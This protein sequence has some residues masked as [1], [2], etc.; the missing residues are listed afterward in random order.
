MSTALFSY[1]RQL[2]RE[3]RD[4]PWK[5][6]LS[7]MTIDAL[8]TNASLLS[9]FALWFLFYVVILR[10][11]DPQKLAE[12]FKGYVTQDWLF[13][14]FLA[15]LVFQLNGLY[16]RTRGT[17][18]VQKALV[19][20]R[21]VSLFIVLFVFADYFLFRGILVPRGVTLLGW[22]LMLLTVGGSRLA[23][24]RVLRLYNVE[25]KTDPAKAK[26]IL[27]LG[28]AGYLGSVLT[29]QLL[30]RGFA[31]RILD[32]FLFGE[33]SLEEVRTHPN[34]EVIRG[35]VR[36][37]GAVVQSMRGCDAVV[38]LAA[39]VGDSACEENKQLALE[40]N[41]AATRMLVDVARGYGVRRFIFASSCSVYGAS[42]ATLDESSPLNPLSLYA[43]TKVDSENIILGAKTQEFAPTVLR[44]ATLFGLS[45]RMRFDLVVNLFVARAISSGRIRVVN[46]EQWRPFLHVADAGRAVLA[47]I[48]GAPEAVSGEV[49]NAGAGHLNLR[50]H[51]VAS[52]IARVLPAVQ[53]EN[54]ESEDRRNYRVS[55]EK[56]ERML[57]FTA[58]GTLEFGIE[59]ICAAIRSG[60]IP[61][62]TA[63][64]FNNQTAVRAFA[65]AANGHASPL[66]QLAALSRVAGTPH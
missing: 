6:T 17:R 40:V 35:D 42:L 49:F 9:A 18:G 23:K 22:L 25:L 11:P 30:S 26:K 62:F 32:S 44:L 12:L 51:E 37:I 15:L 24:H 59:E 16:P 61:D 63:D 39:I 47:C 13:W 34:C 53:C 1:W 55:F 43:Q 64:Q 28:G 19:V 21:A 33:K 20:F 27:V 54:V 14:S 36:D 31:V 2:R 50:I 60:M 38:D 65:A 41:C 3:A 57:G 52:A 56:I 10:T 8:L 29:P 5:H 4:Y 45:P 46:G 66:Q 58:Q 7:R 48:E